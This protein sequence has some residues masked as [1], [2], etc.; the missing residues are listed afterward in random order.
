MTSHQ[1]EQICCISTDA[2]QSPSEVHSCRK[3]KLFVP[4]PVRS[5]PLTANICKMLPKMAFSP[6][7]AASRLAQLKS[8]I[9]C[10]LNTEEIKEQSKNK[11][12]K[13]EESKSSNTT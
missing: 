13:D 6:N 2:Q 9:E 7:G 3:S 10:Q 11:F 1:V 4:K 5:P 12:D 8:F